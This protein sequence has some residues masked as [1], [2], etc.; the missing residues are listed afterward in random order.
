GGGVGGAGNVGDGL[1]GVD[2]P[3]GPDGPG[4]Q[5]DGLGNVDHSK[6]D[7][8]QKDRPQGPKGGQYAT[9]TTG[10]GGPNAP[11]FE[12]EADVSFNGDVEGRSSQATSGPRGAGSTDFSVEADVASRPRNLAQES[13][14]GQSQFSGE[15][16]EG[17]VART[18]GPD[19][20]SVLQG[21]GAGIA[22]REVG[23]SAGVNPNAGEQ[24]AR[25][26]KLQ[27][28]ASVEVV[29]D[30]AIGESGYSNP[31]TELAR[32]DQLAFH[33]KD[34]LQ[35]KANV[36][37][38]ARDRAESTYADPRSAAKAEAS[39]S[40]NE[41]LRESSPL[42]PNRVQGDASKAAA[43]VRDPE[44]AATGEVDL[45]ID[46]KE[47][48]AAAKVGVDGTGTARNRPEPGGKDKP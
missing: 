33:E 44:A 27:A 14:L 21:G 18:V 39:V 30:G 20:K 34:Q 40:A 9:P 3:G 13:E 43:A 10:V 5:G 45:E 8:F 19:G 6:A 31:E 25:G 36:A 4:G 26:E 1:G 23:S 38:N 46:A 17:G 41:A 32:G 24:V 42:D 22:E 16:A 2:H 29:R 7:G 35:A 12:N 11:G 48:E 37:E 47:R 28:N 15:S